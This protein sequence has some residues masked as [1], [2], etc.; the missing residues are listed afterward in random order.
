MEKKKEKKGQ[1]APKGGGQVRFDHYNHSLRDIFPSAI[2]T[3]LKI[4][5]CRYSLASH[6]HRERMEEPL[7]ATK[8]ETETRRWSARIKSAVR[9]VKDEGRKLGYIAGPM[10]AITLSQYMIQVVSNM[11]VGHL[12]QLA[13]CS[14]AIATSFTTAIGFSLLQGMASGLETL[15]GQAY[16]AKQYQ[17]LGT[18]TYSAIL[19]LLFLAIPISLIWASIGK[20]LIFIGQD[21]SISKEAQKY[22]LYMIPSI[23]ASAIGQP[24]IKLLQ[25]QSLVFPML[26]VSILTLCF[27]VPFCYFMVFV[28]GFGNVGAAMAISVSYWVNLIILGIY[29]RFSERCVLTKLTFSRDL[30]D[31]IIEF[32]RVALPSAVMICLEW[33][34]FELLILLSGLLPNPELETSVLSICLTTITTLYSIIYGLGAAASTRVANEL[35]AGNPDRARSAVRVAMFLTVSEAAIVSGTLLASHRVLGYAYSND[36]EVLSYVSRMVPLICVSVVT[37]SIQGVLSGVA[38]GCGWQHLGAY[39]NLGSFYLIGIPFAVLLGFVLKMG[40]RGLWMG[41][42]SGSVTQSTLLIFVT[43]FTNWQHM[44]DRARER[45][46]SGEL[47]LED[48]SA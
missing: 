30:F 45:A 38:R 20:I 8:E 43:V 21:P 33:W 46:F 25:S 36:E 7:L 14:A 11:M 37:D 48:G 28:V 41:I 44:A 12:G 13:L 40:G 27:H 16:G 1:R 42:V 35:G 17:K 15:C 6:S 26:F 47:R 4:N 19:T 23:F 2:K 32:L 10:V 34:S 24:L 29:V 18:Q 31:G 39:V 22:T 3:T 9:E 5:L